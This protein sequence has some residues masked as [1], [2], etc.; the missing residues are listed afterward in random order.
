MKV[1]ETTQIVNYLSAIDNRQVT[2]QT[3]FAWH[4]VIGKLDFEVA[5]QACNLARA[6]ERINY[7]EPKHILAKAQ[8][9]KEAE[10]LK[11]RQAR[12]L[13][14]APPV[15]GVPM[16]KCKHAK[17]LLYCD[18]CCHEDAIKAGLIEPR[19]Y[20]GKKVFH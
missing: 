3:V 14:E 13:E 19:P 11:E 5:R 20:T 18:P 9:L 16:P 7:I 15:V 2:E 12:A 17:G 10:E 4:E 1:L 8:V 6:D